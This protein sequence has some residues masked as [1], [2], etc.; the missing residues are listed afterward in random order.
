MELKN[1]WSDLLESAVKQPGLILKAYS[2]FHGYSLGN[3]LAAMVQC[4]MRSLEPGPINTYQGWKNLNRQVKKGERALW[5]CM[6]L[7]RKAAN[8]DGDEQTVISSFIWRP[9]WFVISQTI[10]EEYQ[11]PAIPLWDKARA[12]AALNITETR[13]EH[14]DGNVLGYARKREVA[15]SPLSKLPWKTLFHELGHV[16]LGHTAETDFNHSERTPRNLRE[17]EAESVALL[18]CETFKLPGAEYCRGYVQN[19]LAAD[20]IPE[21]SAQKIFG[22]ADRILRAGRAE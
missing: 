13:F 19:W 3:Q 7:T 21:K 14:L 5:L 18:L 15:I 1:N 11:M 4:Q 6:P 17:V 12:L 16:V 20:V 8:E 9:N 10:G 2:A 22:T